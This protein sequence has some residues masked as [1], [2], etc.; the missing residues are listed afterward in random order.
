[1]QRNANVYFAG[2]KTIIDGYC[3]R[4]LN[5]GTLFKCCG[6]R[7]AGGCSAEFRGP[8]RNGLVRVVN[9]EHAPDCEQTFDQQ[10]YFLR[11]VLGREFVEPDL[12][13]EFLPELQPISRTSTIG[14]K[15]KAFY[16]RGF[17]PTESIDSASIVKIYKKQGAPPLSAS[18]KQ[19]AWHGLRLEN[20]ASTVQNGFVMDR[21][22]SELNPYGRGAFFSRLSDS[23]IYY[24]YSRRGDKFLVLLLTEIDCDN[25]KEAETEPEAAG[26]DST[27]TVLIKG[28]RMFKNPLECMYSN[29]FFPR[30]PARG[31]IHDMT[32]TSTNEQLRT[33]PQRARVVYVVL[34]K[35]DSWSEELLN[36]PNLRKL[37]LM[38]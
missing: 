4:S 2:G 17:A 21:P 7:G 5:R 25:I 15:I 35:I 13:S 14:T 33:H 3:F 9:K 24:F 12:D 29:V 16:E 11:S 31:N 19:V 8:V 23:G 37:I 18:A 36:N 27:E 10:N 38:H 28:R 26:Y 22:G 6:Y 34:C 30:L 32:S 20:V 1:M